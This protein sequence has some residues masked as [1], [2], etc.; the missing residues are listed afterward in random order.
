MVIQKTSLLLA[1]AASLAL[2]GGCPSPTIHAI[3]DV[4]ES[5]AFT[6]DGKPVAENA[7]PALLELRHAQS[8]ALLLEIHTSPQVGMQHI[9]TAIAAAK[10]AH[11]RLAFGKE[12]APA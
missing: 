7:L 2:L 12:P 6:L 11:I 8:P 5:G 3:L 10:L 1:L 9:Q 4:S